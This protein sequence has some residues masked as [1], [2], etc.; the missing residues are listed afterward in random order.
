MSFSFDEPHRYRPKNIL[1]WKG[2]QESILD[3]CTTVPIYFV[4]GDRIVAM[5]ATDHS[6]VSTSLGKIVHG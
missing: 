5:E 4:I 2:I 6:T 1:H 3:I